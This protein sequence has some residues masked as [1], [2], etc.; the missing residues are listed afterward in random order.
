ME[1]WKDKIMNSLDGMEKAQPP[2]DRLQ[3]IQAAI[4]QQ[5]HIS[6]SP[7]GLSW[8]AVAAVILLVICSN[9][10]V[11]THYFDQTSNISAFETYVPLTANFNIYE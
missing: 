7:K 2:K 10:M 1:E 8:M 11:V 6:V 9:V 4:A 5:H 3:K